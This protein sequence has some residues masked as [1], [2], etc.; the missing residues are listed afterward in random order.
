MTDQPW[1]FDYFWEETSVPAPWNLP[2]VTIQGPVHLNADGSTSPTG[3]TVFT[4]PE[5]EDR[6]AGD[7]RQ[8][9][10]RHDLGHGHPERGQRQ[11]DRHG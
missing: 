11:R 3:P 8:P 9:A 4:E 7:Q 5:V 2:N 1:G 10:G 6:D